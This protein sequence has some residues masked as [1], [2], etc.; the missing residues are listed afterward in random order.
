MRGVKESNQRK[1]DPGIRADG[2]ASHRFPAVLAAQ[3][4]A[5]NSA[6]PGLG[7]FAFPRW[8]A[9]VLGAPQGALFK[10]GQSEGRARLGLGAQDAR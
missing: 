3:R 10:Q 7:Q 1:D 4:P 6:I 5:N 2:T 9:P 8:S